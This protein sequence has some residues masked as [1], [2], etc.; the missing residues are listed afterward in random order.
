MNIG[1]NNKEKIRL[2]I[3]E[4][5]GF[6]QTN[7]RISSENRIPEIVIYREINF[8]EEAYRTNCNVKYIGDLWNDDMSSLII[9]SGEWEFYKD[10]NYKHNNQL[11]K[12]LI[13]LGPGYYPDLRNLLLG[14]NINDVISSF[15]CVKI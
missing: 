4:I 2:P 11:N 14:K 7:E 6:I 8:Q 1:Q 12:P 9:V 5:P 13:I 15:K 10:A 3:L